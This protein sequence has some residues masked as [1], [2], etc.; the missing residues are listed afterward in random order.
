MSINGY[1]N[2]LKYL[3]NE[4]IQYYRISKQKSYNGIM[5]RINMECD[6]YP[7]EKNFWDFEA[8]KTITLIDK[9]IYEMTLYNAE[10]ANTTSAQVRKILADIDH[11]CD[12]Y[13]WYEEK[14]NPNPPPPPE[15]DP[16]WNEEDY[17]IGVEYLNE[18]ILSN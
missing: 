14:N 1:V 11:R 12:P 6:I 2:C 7:R 3:I 4:A 18:T 15:Q 17:A 10:E 13:R 16:S 5:H 9:H 8:D